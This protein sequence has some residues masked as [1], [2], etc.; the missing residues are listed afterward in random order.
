MIDDAVALLNEEQEDG[1]N[2]IDVLGKSQ[3]EDVTQT[4]TILAT[5]H[6]TKMRRPETSQ[7]LPR[8]QNERRSNI[9]GSAF[10]C[11]FVC[12]GAASEAR[13]GYAH[14]QKHVPRACSTNVL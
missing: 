10:L 8:R 6:P 4:F 1:K 14:S 3:I 2:D 11:V 7:F 13:F 9:R 5:D 12:V